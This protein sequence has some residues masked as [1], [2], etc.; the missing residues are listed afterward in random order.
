MMRRRRLIKQEEHKEKYK[1]T[2]R[3]IITR[4]MITKNEQ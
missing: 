3:T 2:L 1:Q 4:R